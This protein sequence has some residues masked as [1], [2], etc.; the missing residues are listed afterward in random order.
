MNAQV[1]YDLE[2][3]LITVKGGATLP[4]PPVGVPYL[5]TILPE[6]KYVVGVDVSVMPHELIL[7]D[8]PP[9][10]TQV[11]Q[12]ALSEASMLI[13]TQQEQID[14]ANKAISELTMIIAGGNA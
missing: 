12:Q 2:G 9:S 10:E 7:E 5:E 6:R 11:L 4:K 13:A 14:N 8:I 3:N 1:I